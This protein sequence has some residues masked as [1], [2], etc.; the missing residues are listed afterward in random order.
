MRHAI[1]NITRHKS[2][3]LKCFDVYSR[4]IATLRSVAHTIQSVSVRVI[5]R[6][7]WRKDWSG[8]WP[9]YLWEPLCPMVL[10]PAVVSPTRAPHLGRTI[11]VWDLCCCVG[12]G[13]VTGNFPLPCLWRTCGKNHIIVGI[14]QD[15][16]NVVSSR[17]FLCLPD[18]YKQTCNFAKI[19]ITN[20]I[21]II[22][23]VILVLCHNLYFSVLYKNL[24]SRDFCYV[25][26]GM[27]TT[28]GALCCTR[29]RVLPSP[30]NYPVKM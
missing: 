1:N 7:W 4:S 15:F 3:C 8:P 22:H 2:L 12:Q 27:Y 14:I 30:R 20:F 11:Q 21:I 26:L 16:I 5:S 6:V 17:F 28:A 25:P 10:W 18:A 9:S 23:G 19:E 29:H 24:L 13:L